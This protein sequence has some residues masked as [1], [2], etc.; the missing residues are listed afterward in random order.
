MFDGSR[1]PVRARSTKFA[2]VEPPHIYVRDASASVV[3]H[4]DYLNSRDD[5]ALCGIAIANPTRMAPAERPTAVCPDC[6]AKLV[7]YHLVWWR[8]R[9]RA[10]TAELDELR[11]KYRELVENTDDQRG[12]LAALQP[13]MQVR[14]DSDAQ[15]LD[16]RGKTAEEPQGDS[17]AERADAEPAS[18][19]DHA[20]KE[21]LDLCRQFDAAVPYRRV[22]NTM[23]AFSDKLDPDERV[24]LAQQISTSGSLIRWST[25]EV[26]NLGWHVS[27]NPVQ[28]EPEEM[29]D[30]WTR[31]SYQTPKQGRWRLGRSRSRD[32]S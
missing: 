12:Q 19:L 31:D 23:Q 16:Q 25:T 29:W 21:L 27:G 8:D 22:K 18:L 32:S 13:R 15:A 10:A 14:G 30:A 24:L 1:R 17:P 28:G 26:E 7:E 20:R 9:A 6:E 3:H 2:D 11:T 5:H 4:G